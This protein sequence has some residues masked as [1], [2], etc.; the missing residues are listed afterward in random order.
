MQPEM[1]PAEGETLTQWGGETVKIVRIEKDRDIPLV[2]WTNTHSAFISLGLSLFPVWWLKKSIT[3]KAPSY[4]ELCRSMGLGF[5]LFQIILQ[6]F[7]SRIT[8]GE[9]S[10]LGSTFK[11]S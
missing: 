9:I 6:H 7:G 8:T 4:E 1:L 10:G 3:L 11:F 2:G 5:A